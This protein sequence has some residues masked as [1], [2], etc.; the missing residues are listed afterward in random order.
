MDTIYKKIGERDE[1]FWVHF[2]SAVCLYPVEL[3]KICVKNQ[4]NLLTQI[5]FVHYTKVKP[6]IHFY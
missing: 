5:F 6:N 3:G 1:N 2:L 4:E